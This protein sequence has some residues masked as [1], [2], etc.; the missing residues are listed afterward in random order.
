M[1]TPTVIEIRRG[2]AHREAVTTRP[3]PTPAPRA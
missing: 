1:L 2:C 3:L